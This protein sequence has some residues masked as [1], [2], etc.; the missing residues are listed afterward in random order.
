MLS[1]WHSLYEIN[2]VEYEMVITV[3]KWQPLGTNWEFNLAKIQAYTK[4]NTQHID[5]IDYKVGNWQFNEEYFNLSH[6]SRSRCAGHV[7][8]LGA[9]SFCDAWLARPGTNQHTPQK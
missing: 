1:K 7:V 5:V 9:V 3:T 6:I 4:E 2:A 8:L